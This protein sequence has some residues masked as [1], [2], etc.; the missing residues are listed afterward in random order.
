M[1]EK[2]TGSIRPVQRLPEDVARKIAAGEVIDRPASILR[3]LLDNAVDSGADS[4]TVEITDGGIGKISVSDNGTGMTKA[5]LENCA[6]PHT[7]SKITSESDLQTLTTLG[8]R[9]EALASI[10]AVSRLEII[11]R[12]KDEDLSWKMTA[13]VAGKGE[14]QIS[15]ANRNQGTV[16]TSQ[17]L[18]ENIPA[19]RIFLKRPATEAALCKQIF[20]EKALPETD[21]A[22]KLIIDGKTKFNLVAG[23]TPAERFAEAFEPGAPA[24]LFSTL[25]IK[26][27]HDNNEKWTATLLLSDTAV[28]R[29][30][31]KMMLV[32]VNGRRIQEYSLLQAIEYGAAGFFPNGTHPVACL[33]IDIAPSLVDFNIHP[34][35]KEVRFKDIS[36]LHHAVSTTVRNFY[37]QNASLNPV[38]ADEIEEV[39]EEKSC[40]IAERESPYLPGEKFSGIN[41]EKSFESRP[42][43]D[44]S[45]SSSGFSNSSYG[46]NSYSRSS[47]TENPI[48]EY[49]RADFYKRPA[50]NGTFFSA[51]TA[52]TQA[53]GENQAEAPSK[54]FKYIGRIMDVFIL[55]E[56]DDSLFIVD[57]HAGHE[58]ILFDRFMETAG[59]RQNLLVPYRIECEDEAEEQYVESISDELD[60]AGFTIQKI[61]NGFEITTIPEK[62]KGTGSDL[63]NSII[64]QKIP[65]ADIIRTIAAYTA[66]RSAVKEGDYID[67][68]TAINIAKQSF[69]L[70]D[71]H[72]PHGRPVWL[73]F[74]RTDLYK[75]IKRI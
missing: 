65:P 13:P 23:Q 8:F 14:N 62:W 18:F 1:S 34:A 75:L 58:R 63:R 43:F 17:A 64:K 47:Y 27:S 53:L 22:F 16:V 70:E 5:D 74:S 21:I 35:K 54:N 60:K 33:F 15:P 6:R 40:Q 51:D 72:C 26:G 56:K 69:M 39:Y 52:A 30:D 20:I 67:S 50:E 71:P 44:G 46:S 42:S 24:S 2:R 38:S 68:E 59:K 10:A 61:E 4:I 32:Y 45:Y 36:A 55:I 66:C 41:D 31:K 28:S 3:E 9:G 49:F 37:R 48:K 7:T 12:R 11:S 19:R 73:E 25:T 29:P 57:Q